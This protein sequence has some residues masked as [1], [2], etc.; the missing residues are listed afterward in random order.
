MY[1]TLRYDTYKKN[2]AIQVEL[3]PTQDENQS[4]SLLP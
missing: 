2:R 4:S 3:C 1:P